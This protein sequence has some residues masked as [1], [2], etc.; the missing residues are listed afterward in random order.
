MAEYFPNISCKSAET[1][2]ELEDKLKSLPPG[3][4]K[5]I[6]I[7][8]KAHGFNACYTLQ[9]SYQEKPTVYLPNTVTQISTFDDYI[10]VYTPDAFYKLPLS[11]MNKPI[12]YIFIPLTKNQ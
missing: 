6:A 12:D 4:M 7:A 3:I 5:Q 11:Y 8:E 10:G 9:N 2:K 1:F